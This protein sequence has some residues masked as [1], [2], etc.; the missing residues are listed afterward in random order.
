MIS[1]THLALA[2]LMV[3]GASTHVAIDSG[4]EDHPGLPLRSSPATIFAPNII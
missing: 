3:N 1:R 2:T 4:I